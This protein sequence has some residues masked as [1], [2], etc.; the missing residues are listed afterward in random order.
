MVL[1]KIIQDN[2]TMKYMYIVRHVSQLLGMYYNRILH[3]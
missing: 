1:L 3:T 2:L